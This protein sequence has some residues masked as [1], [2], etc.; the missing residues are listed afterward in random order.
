MITRYFNGRILRYH[1]FVEE[2]LWVAKGKIIPPQKKSDLEVDVKGKFL[3]PGYID[4]QINGGFGVDF[5]SQPEQVDQV[6]KKLTQYGVTAFI[7]TLVSLSANRYPN[8]L[9]F[10][11]PKAGGAHG[12]SILGIH[13]EGPFF[14]AKKCGA[15]EAKVI[16]EQVSLSALERCYGDL[17][18]VK[19]ITLAPEIPGAL[20]T[21]SELVKKGIVVAAGHTLA[22]YE[23][24]QKAQKAG[25]KLV[26]HLFNAMPSFHHR[27]PGVIGACLNCPQLYFSIIPDLVHLH[28][29]A[30]QIAWKSHP[31][32][33]ILI[34]DAMQSLGMPIGKY[35]LGQKD[36]ETRKEAVYL[37][38]TD[39]LAGS[40][41]S[42][43][44]AV[45]NFSLQ[46]GVSQV[47]AIE[48]ASLKPAALLNLPH[49]GNLSIGSD[50]DFILLD[51]N[52]HVQSCYVNGELCA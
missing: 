28:E 33:L 6:A 8:I 14:S 39:T 11:Q 4:I 7:P 40:N 16:Q 29:T 35:Q 3:A 42:M 38:G 43:D 51:Q 25:L 10:L 34:T 24:M 2:E 18:G 26:T 36:V 45:R 47:A 37:E 15:H 48:A 44:Q 23:E 20:N 21:I 41:L 22:N 9:P 32:G 30:L 13:L 1:A 49:K 12:A 17:T 5:T 46:A 52:L 50:A 19:I 31:N 27:S